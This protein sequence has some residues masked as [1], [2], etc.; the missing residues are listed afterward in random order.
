MK[1]FLFYSAF[2]FIS[3]NT[4]VC[5]TSYFNNIYVFNSIHLTSGQSIILSD[6][7]Y[8]VVASAIDT[9]GLLKILLCNADTSNGNII[10]KKLIGWGYNNFYLGY[11]GCFQK[12]SDNNLFV[13]GVREDTIQST[14]FLLKVNSSF[15][16]LFFK[17]YADTTFKY[18]EFQQGKE[19]YDKGFILV[20]TLPGTGTYD[21]NIVVLK[22][23][24]AGNEQWRK[25]FDWGGVE[26]ARNVI[27]TPDGGYLLGCYIY[28][29]D[30]LSGDGVVLKLDT[31][32]NFEWSRNIGGPNR[33]GVPVIALAKDSNYIVAT[34]YAYETIFGGGSR[35]K[36]QV[37]KINK[38]DHSI[39]WDKQYDTIRNDCYS[40]MIKVI[41]DGTIFITGVSDIWDGINYYGASWILKLNSNGDSLLYRRFWKYNDSHTTN[42]TA[43]DF[44]V[45]NDKS[46]VICGEVKLD[47]AYNY[48]WLAKM[49]SLG[50]LQPGC[51]IVGVE[52][53]KSDIAELTVYPN[54]ATNSITFNTGIYQ[55]FKLKIFNAIGQT[56]LQKQLAAYN[57]TLNIQSFRQGM[58][59]YT[60][61][62]NK[63]KVISGKFVKN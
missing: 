47:T 36:I 42:N 54:P 27:Q 46:I 35:L 51:D 37:L 41:N 34:A 55:D 52:E 57:T 9:T 16:T 25:I 32:G 38:S 8:K 29:T 45:T 62:N 56:V 26:Y 28:N 23:D 59:Y 58:Y 30:Y 3:I 33:D 14:A 4:I 10:S 40:N 17:E 7:S 2:F 21:Q 24:S 15:D 50:C 11:S 20:G 13:V 49:D 6:S 43:Y 48:L 1:K 44:C 61:I 22:T 60:L 19:T 39:I 53:I 12:T 31:F 5:Q 18:L 63:G